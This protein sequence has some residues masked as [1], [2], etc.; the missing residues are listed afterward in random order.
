MNHLINTVR[1]SAAQQLKHSETPNLDI[2][3]LLC[4]VLKKTRT[5]LLTHLDESLTDDQFQLF[6]DLLERR[7]HGEPIAYI[8]GHADFYN[9]R[10]NVTPDVLIPRPETECLVDYICSLPFSSNEIDAADLG[11][12]SGAIALSLAKQFAYWHIDAVD[13]SEAALNLAKHNATRL[14]LNHVN[15]HLG[16]WCD[17]LPK[18]QYDMIISNPPYVAN[19]EKHLLNAD[20]F[21]EPEQALFSQ[22]HGFSDLL[23]IAQ[24][25]KSYLKPKGYLILEHGYQQGERLRTILNKLNYTQVK[26]HPDLS[27]HERFTV[28][29]F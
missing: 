11:T 13:V 28:A 22:D 6:S 23:L 24:Q 2:D 14:E 26:T 27:N 7:I 4:H 10:L 8:L 1:S 18:K 5:T 15:F 25:A 3:L 21:F 9:I 29:Q 20:V 19:S 17:A 12:G 16:S